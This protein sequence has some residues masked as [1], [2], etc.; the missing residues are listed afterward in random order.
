MVSGKLRV[1]RRS[2]EDGLALD[3]DNDAVGQRG[4][5][6]FAPAADR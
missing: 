3:Q 4:Q 5:N 1:L 6:V 2:L